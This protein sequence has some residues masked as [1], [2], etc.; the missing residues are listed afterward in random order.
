[1]PTLIA[2]KTSSRLVLRTRTSGLLARFAHDLEINAT[3][4]SIRATADGD[5]WSAEV[6]IPVAAL[7][8]EGVLKGGDKLDTGVLSAS[9][10]AEIEQ[11]IRSEILAPGPD[12]TAQASGASRERGEAWDRRRAF[13]HTADALDGGRMRV[14]G[15]RA[16][17]PAAP[18]RAETCAL[19]VG[20]AV[21]KAHVA[22]I[23][24]A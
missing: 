5:S 6:A 13:D 22:R 19:G 21:M 16:F 3:E 14:N 18:A 2:D 17:R 20:C 10:R 11:R 23:R 15:A 12:V 8:V 4:L 24:P 7:R 1:M 9:D